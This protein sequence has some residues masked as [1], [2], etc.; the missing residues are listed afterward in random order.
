MF[1]SVSAV[2]RTYFTHL[3]RRSRSRHSQT[4]GHIFVVTGF[5]RTRRDL[6]LT[7]SFSPAGS[8]QVDISDETDE[9]QEFFAGVLVTV[10]CSMVLC[11][12]WH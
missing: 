3:S 2:G 1:I 8:V 5:M 6:R 4:R 9:S 7:R 10:H 12:S 11:V